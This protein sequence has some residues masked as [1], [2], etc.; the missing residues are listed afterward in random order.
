[1]VGGVL[2]RAERRSATEQFDRRT[3]LLAAAVRTETGRYVDTLQTLAAATG[4]IPVLTTSVFAAATAPLAAMHLAGASSIAFIVPAA[5]EQ[6]PAVQAY[7]RTRSA[8]PLTLKP[9]RGTGEHQFGIFS[10]ALDPRTRSSTL[11]IDLAQA[12]APSQALAEARR[13]GSVTASDT[14]QLLIDRRLPPGARQLSFVLTAPVYEA[15]GAFRGWILMGLRGQDFIGTTLER[16]SQGL[17]DVTLWAANSTRTQVPVARLHDAGSGEPDL[18]GDL[19][20]AVADRIWRLHVDANSTAM[21]GADGNL[22]L[23]VLVAGVLVSLLL[24]TLV[25]VLA[26]ARSRAQQRVRVATAELSAAEA[27]ARRQA[28]LLE[29]VLESIS[30]G[31]GVVDTDG[32]FLLHNPAAKAM[33]GIGEDRGGPSNWQEHYGIFTEDGVTPFPADRLPLVRALGGESTNQVEMVVRNAGQPEGI[34]ITVSGRPLNAPGQT[35]A[36]AV[37][38]D[39]TAR[40]RADRALAEA[41]AGL[42]AELIRREAT[43]AELRAFA[44]VV[45]HDLKSPLTSV[46]GYAELLRDSLAGEP[47]DPPT[48]DQSAAGRILQGAHRMQHLIDDLLSY[49]T[50]RDG[51]C[52]PEAVDLQALAADVVAERTEHL[53]SG[54]T[55]PAGSPPLFPDVYTGPLPL[56]W[57]DRAML[58]QLLDNLLGNAL[59]YTIPGQPARIDISAHTRP[60]DDQVRIEIADR[61]IGIPDGEHERI[62]TPFYRVQTGRD[63]TG[64]GLGLAIC[65]RIADRHGGS[66]GVSDNPGGGSRFWFTLTALPAGSLA[67]PLPVAVPGS[68]S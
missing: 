22:A 49:A 7:W 51:A 38:H 31:V 42:H 59:K 10:R 5:T 64:T 15:G 60:G 55:S 28:G 1:M 23:T 65:R 30:D 27:E 18:H 4:T 46:A 47:G 33:L 14:Y 20:V 25:F 26:T 34:A 40:K 54:G 56:V 29:A 21:P 39:V 61:G 68:R 53:R 6:V 50:A 35:G 58:R 8:G 11:G 16:L 32:E 36:V 2:D 9:A 67:D 57:A 43:E 3:S 52:Q 62:F 66:L 24:T 17:L 13:T 44:G 37:F 45:A 48:R 41:M 19:T 12:A 63:Y